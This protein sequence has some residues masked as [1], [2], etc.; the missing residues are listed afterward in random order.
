MTKQ[1]DDSK[2]VT[3]V[4]TVQV[5]EP[6]AE[7]VDER[8]E[9]RDILLELQNISDIFLGLRKR[10]ENKQLEIADTR[11]NLQRVSAESERWMNIMQLALYSG[12]EEVASDAESSF[13][14][15]NKDYEMLTGNLAQQLVELD[16]IKQEAVPLQERFLTAKN[17]LRELDHAADS[18][19]MVDM[20]VFDKQ[21][22]EEGEYSPETNTPK[23]DALI[24]AIELERARR[25]SAVD[26]EAMT[27][28][29]FEELV[30]HLYER[31]GFDVDLTQHSRDGG[32]DVYARRENE[33]GVEEIAVQ[34]KHY[35][36]AV[37]VAE[38]RALL[39]VLDD[40]KRL[41]RGCSLPADRSLSFARSLLKGIGLISLTERT[42]ASC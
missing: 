22:E 17:R 4:P 30:G 35:S 1:G 23:A 18:D 41:A 2:T 24:R 5:D 29:E 10:I 13:R 19:E 3:T 38:A 14:K 6:G 12:R 42:C 31:M 7:R 40:Q 9:V 21:D 15:H 34:C 28:S 36:G 16:K 11:Q 37:G 8:K 32:V 25:K 26:L 27:P 33:A 39:G 20:S